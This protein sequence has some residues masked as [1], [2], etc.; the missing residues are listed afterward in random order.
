MINLFLPITIFTLLVTQKVLLLNEESLILICFIV[1]VYLGIM[2]VGNYL[3]SFLKIQIEEIKS[4]L[5]KSLE[6]LLKILLN[7]KSLS[8]TFQNFLQKLILLKSY[9]K[10]LI[11]FLNKYLKIYNKNILTQYYSKKLF[12]LN[13]IEDQ[14]IKLFTILVLKKLNFIIKTKFFYTNLIKT[15]QFLSLNYI[16]I[17]ECIYLIDMKNI[18]Y[19]RI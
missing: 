6:N 8:K 3:N 7:L 1:F 12:F 18:K 11:V 5:K 9:Y 13:N 10:G 4:N 17:R 2:K 15:S 16:Y 14:T 19:K